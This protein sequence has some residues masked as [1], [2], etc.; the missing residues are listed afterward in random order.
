MRW[1]EQCFFTDE[2]GIMIEAIVAVGRSWQIGLDGVLPWRDAD[3]LRWFRSMTIGKRCIV[4]H[5]TALRLPSLQGREL[6]VWNHDNFTSLLGIDA[7]VIGG[8]ATYKKFAPYIS[9]W[10]IGRIDYDGPADTFFDRSW[11]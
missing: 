5:N 7:I 8:A 4:G 11:I 10:H 9:R 3:D 2:E 6:V 1:M